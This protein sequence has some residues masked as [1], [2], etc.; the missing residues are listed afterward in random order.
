MAAAGSGCDTSAVTRQRYK[1]CLVVGALVLGACKDEAK[2]SA[3]SAA[4]AAADEGD[5][6]DEADEAGGDSKAEG[7]DGQTAGTG[8]ARPSSDTAAN[9]KKGGLA[10]LALGIVTDAKEASKT[11]VTLIPPSARVVVHV[12]LEPLRGLKIYELVRDAMLKETDP[13]KDQDATLRRLQAC[14]LDPDK[15]KS[16]TLG[17][18]DGDHTVGVIKGP[19]FGKFSNL[20]CFEKQLEADGKETGFEIK[21]VDGEKVLEDE[22]DRIYSLGDDAI[23]LVDKEL[24]D[25]TLPL[26]NGK[27]DN[28]TGGPLAKLLEG[29]DQ[30]KDAWFVAGR[31]GK[32][33][34]FGYTA[35]GEAEA[36]HG[37]M[38][39]TGG[40][41]S[42]AWTIDAKS[43]TAAETI[44]SE[45]N[46][47]VG[48][49]KPMGSMFG[50]PS[51]LDKKIDVE[52]EDEHVTVSMTL[53]STELDAVASAF[54]TF[55]R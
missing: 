31:G 1:S 34:P 46:R 29:V 6:A 43:D 33:S 21:T 16:L 13:D 52:R 42:W 4:P 48:Q 36:M 24:L 40:D 23:L 11:P 54:R 32:S 51:G 14:N 44:E 26:R 12:E 28:V 30:N 10:G 22:G 49:L 27:G 5:E 3:D 19:G 17:V 9:P 50:L 53:T 38:D 39:I 41:L 8:P 2:P 55:L 20:E 18:D 37:V 15:A 47:G 45:I 7:D 35:M 25:A